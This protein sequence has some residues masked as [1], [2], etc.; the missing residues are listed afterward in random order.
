MSDRINLNMLGNK[1]LMNMF[2][3]LGNDK[4]D[5][6][7]NNFCTE[8]NEANNPNTKTKRFKFNQ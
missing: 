3:A 7:I 4:K 8:G 6:R 5:A 1:E 2:K